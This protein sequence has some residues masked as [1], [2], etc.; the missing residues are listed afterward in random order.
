MTGRL[1]PGCEMWAV[2]LLSRWVSGPWPGPGD[3]E[4]GVEEGRGSASTVVESNACTACPHSSGT[5][6]GWDT[7]KR[8]AVVLSNLCC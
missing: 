8:R 6:E 5:I 2:G 7:G 1:L 3:G 4:W